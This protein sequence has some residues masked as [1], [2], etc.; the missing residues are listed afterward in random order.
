M[1]PHLMLGKSNATS[2]SPVHGWTHPDTEVKARWIFFFAVV[3]IT[4]PP[5]PHPILMA[6][7]PLSHKHS[8]Q[9]KLTVSPLL[10]FSTFSVPLIPKNSKSHRQDP[11]LAAHQRPVDNANGKRQR[12]EAH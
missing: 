3:K 2:H 5:T 7:N 9:P 6:L 8:P 1:C 11:A 12:D 10:T 4:P